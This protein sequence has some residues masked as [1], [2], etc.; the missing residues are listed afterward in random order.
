MKQ[1]V[2]RKKRLVKENVA[3]MFMDSDFG[4]EI[5][6][7]L[8]KGEKRLKRFLIYDDRNGEDNF[9]EKIQVSI[10]QTIR[11]KYLGNDAEYLSAARIADDQHKFYLIEQTQEYQPFDYLNR[12]EDETEC[13]SIKERN[14]AEAV[15]FRFRRDSAVIWA[16]QHIYAASIPNK[17][18]QNFLARYFS[19]EQEDYFVEMADPLFVITRKVDLLITGNVI[20]T[21]NITLMQKHFKFETFIRNSAKAAA[22]SIADVGIVFDADKLI[23]YVKRPNKKYARRMMRISEYNVL[24]QNPQDLLNRIQQVDRWKD[25]FNIKDGKI[26]LKTYTDVE[27]LIDLFNERYTISEIT[28]DEFDT[29]VKKLMK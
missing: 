20:V 21:D 19:R 2:S 14:E 27:N 18:E 8:K 23:D 22:Q 28:G 26:Q 10:E 25:M 4:F 13:F 16:Y 29:D 6:I 3:A 11:D 17:K 5:F 1:T 9:K 7:V 24:N 12:Q 15:L